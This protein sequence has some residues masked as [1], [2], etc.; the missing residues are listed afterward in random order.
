MIIYDGNKLTANQVAKEIVF[1][2]GMV[3]T[4]YWGENGSLEYD[5]LTAK[6][7]EDIERCCENQL[8][9][10]HKLLFKD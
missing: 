1:D 6:E 10:V 5:K 9:R 8:I 7:R 3:G 4:E 2:K